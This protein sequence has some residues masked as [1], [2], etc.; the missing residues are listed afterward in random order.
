MNKLLDVPTSDPDDAR[1]RKLLNILL[2]GIGGLSVLTFLVVF[3][4]N[5]FVP[6]KNQNDILIGLGASVALIF[7]LCGIL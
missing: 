4:L 1:R 3:F 2:A 6:F 7:G 5:V